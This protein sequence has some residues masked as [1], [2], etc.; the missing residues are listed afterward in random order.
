MLR[1]GGAERLLDG[2]RQPDAQDGPLPATRPAVQHALPP[3]PPLQPTVWAREARLPEPA[4][5]RQAGR[6]EAVGPRACLPQVG[7]SCTTLLR[8]DTNCVYQVWEGR[9]GSRRF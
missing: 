3:G 8:S 9:A 1:G 5:G 6:G 7:G 2:V 4:A